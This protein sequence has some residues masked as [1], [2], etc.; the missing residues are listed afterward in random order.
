[1]CHTC[2]GVNCSRADL[3]ECNTGATY[4]MNTMT[5]DQNG[6]RTITRGCVSENECFSKWWII[7]ADDPRCLSM[8]NT[9]T[10]QP[11]QPIE[12]NYCCK[13]AGCNQIL[14]IPDS[15]LYTGEDHPSSGIGG[16]IQIG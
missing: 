14:R 13:G 9:P 3:Q 11:G 1:M 12:C 16:V 7:T 2:T 15:L 5:Q 6:I 4:C 8:K 10:G